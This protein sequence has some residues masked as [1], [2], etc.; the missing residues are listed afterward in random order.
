MVENLEVAIMDVEEDILEF[1]AYALT[2][3]DY[4]PA[5]FMHEK[6]FLSHVRRHTPPAVIVGNCDGVFHL[7]DCH[8]SLCQ[9]VRR[10]PGMEDAVI[11]CLTTRQDHLP[12]PGT[13]SSRANTG[14]D[15]CILTPTKPANII[16]QLDRL[17]TRRRFPRSSNGGAEHVA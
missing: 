16:R 14:A 4:A 2:K 8:R 3:A 13:A 1:L 5:C 10:L 11:L 12:T 7:P 9:R 6:D 17:L 15:L